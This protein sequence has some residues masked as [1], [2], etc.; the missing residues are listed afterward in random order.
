MTSRDDTATAAADRD[1][2]RHSEA[3]PSTGI[4]IIALHISTQTSTTPCSEKNHRQL[5]KSLD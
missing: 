3:A 5:N 2:V 4:I 1:D